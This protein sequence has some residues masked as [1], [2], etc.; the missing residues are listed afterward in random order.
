MPEADFFDDEETDR[1]IDKALDRQ[2]RV[3]EE[4]VRD[5]KL[6][7]RVFSTD[8]GEAVLRVLRRAAGLGGE[9]TAS[10]SSPMPLGSLELAA[11]EGRREM[12]WLIEGLRDSLR[13][14]LE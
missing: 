13:E 11:L 9:L 10:D 14:G 2:R 7:H 1:R 3:R 5:A 8:D 6:F 12:V 4:T